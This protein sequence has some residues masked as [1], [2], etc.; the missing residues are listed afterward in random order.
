MMPELT[1]SEVSVTPRLIR[2][3][4]HRTDVRARSGPPRQAERTKRYLERWLT[5]KVRAHWP[6]YGVVMSRPDVYDERDVALRQTFI[7]VE[8][9]AAPVEGY[10][11]QMVYVADFDFRRFHL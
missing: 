10:A 3:T 9:M 7:T 5:R 8:C 4:F 1:V 2:Y 11:G 6:R